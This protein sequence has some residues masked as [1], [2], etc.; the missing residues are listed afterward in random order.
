MMQPISIMVVE[1]EGLVSLYLQK[2]LKEFGYQIAGSA[3][4]G[5]EALAKINLLPP[6]L[7]MMDYQL[8]GKLTG[9]QTAKLIKETL[10]IPIIFLTAYSNKDT[11][12]EII[13]TEPFGYLL[14]PVDEKVLYTTIETALT[15]H[16]LESKLKEQ[17]QLVRRLNNDLEQRVKERTHELKVANLELKIQIGL[18][19]VLENEL[20]LSLEKEKELSEL[21]TRFIATTSHE[22]RTPLSI[23][24]SSSEMLGTYGHRWS[25]DKK[26]DLLNRIIVAVKHMTT[27]LQDVLFL[28]KDDAGKLEFQPQ[29]N[30][31]RKFLLQIVEEARTS[32][33]REWQINFKESNESQVIWLDEK[34]LHQILN[35]LLSNAMKYSPD[36][37]KIDLEL[38]WYPNKVEI[39]VRDY[40]IGIPLADQ[41]N[42]FESFF[43]AKNVGSIGGTGLGLSILKRAVDRHGGHIKV[44]ST[45]G[46]GTTFTVILPI[47]PPPI[48]TPNPV[49]TIH[50]DFNSSVEELEHHW[51]LLERA[52]ESTKTGI[53]I[54]DQRRPN[55]PIVYCNSGF[56]Q[57][58]GYDRDEILGENYRFLLEEDSTQPGLSEARTA[59]LEGRDATV[60]LRNYRKDG[61]IFLNELNLSPIKDNAGAVINIIGTMRDVTHQN[62]GAL[63]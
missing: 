50:D 5:E 57:M 12:E 19:S 17:E 10:D 56:E 18:R 49:P 46:N 58:T 31:L 47:T 9:V 14:K 59:M 37:Q 55:W 21:K 33:L 54:I 13:K 24:L 40:G 15:R 61:T 16:R 52:V 8:K 51:S 28:N 1:D 26:K 25:E 2:T 34:L 23:I 41:A 38:R 30:D 63:D 60:I 4:S 53:I 29:P 45:E 36:H 35:N 43:R 39:S 42:L 22:F 32:D 48:P 7:I 11:L 62:Y 6:D 27:M 44:E 20:R 3:F